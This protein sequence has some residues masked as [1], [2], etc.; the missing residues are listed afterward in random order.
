MR[1]IEK[2]Y[3]FHPY[4]NDYMYQVENNKI[5]SCREQKLLMSFLREKLANPDIMMDYGIVEKSVEVPG[6]Y[7]PFQLYDWEKFINC[8]I[9]GMRYKTG[10]LVFDKYF[11]LLGRGAGKNGFVSYNSFFMMTKHLGISEYSI[12][13]VATSEDQCKRSFDDVYDVLGDPG[14]KA[15]SK[16]F[17]KSKVLIKHKETKSTLQYNTSNARTKDSKR[18]G[19][20]IFDEVHDFIRSS[21][22][23]SSKN[24]LMLIIRHLSNGKE[25]RIRIN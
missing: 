24:Q 18:T 13:L 19:V 2:T 10:E 4:I 5:E 3:N 23:I 16:S 21:D 8:F 11:L 17:Y 6:R 7:F 12:D 25:N 1:N 14:N 15:L 20:V 9:Y 22:K